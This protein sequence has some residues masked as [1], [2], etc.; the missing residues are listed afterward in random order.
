MK[1]YPYV[2]KFQQAIKLFYA[3]NKFELLESG[4]GLSRH[5]MN[6]KNITREYLSNTWGVVESKEHAEFIIELCKGHGIEIFNLFDDGITH[7]FIAK[8][9]VIFTYGA[10]TTSAHDKQ[11]TI[12]LP[13]KAKSKFS[14]LRSIFNPNDICVKLSAPELPEAGHNLVFAASE[15]KEWPCVNDRVTW[16][17]LTHKG[18][19]KSISDG[20]AWIKR[21]SGEYET[22]YISSLKKPKTSEEA[23]RDD[24]EYAIH[25][26]EGDKVAGRKWLMSKYNITPKD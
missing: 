22:V 7:F 13:P 12:P 16:G 2:G 1:S 5:E 11:I 8:G 26:F 19:V 14:G 9:E 21:D 25:H 3:P 15:C 6:Y 4:N 20:F 23:L 17:D 10:P 24:L 18:V